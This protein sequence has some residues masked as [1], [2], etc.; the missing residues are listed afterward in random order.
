MYRITFP[1]PP[2]RDLEAEYEQHAG[3]LEKALHEMH[4]RIG[5]TLSGG[6]SHPNI[7][8]RIKSFDSFY[9]KILRRGRHA[10]PHDEI[11]ITDLL[12]IRVVCPFV[13]EISEIEHTLREHYDVIE[14]E[15]KGEHLGST[16]FGYSS[17]H[18]L[19][20]IPRD[21]RDSFHLRGNWV[22]EVQLRTI[23]QD[24]W[25]EVEHELVYKAE[26]TPSTPSSGGNS[27]RSTRTSRYRIS[28]FRRSATISGR[29][30]AN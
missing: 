25:A 3:V 22:C 18:I 10:S 23:L 14:V 12:G 7:K 5:R 28:F 17:I 30:K 8:Y 4:R 9:E 20:Q 1:I 19:I 21:I 6:S 27:R 13:E 2:R 26:L 11:V 24:A 16:E 29:C 15:R